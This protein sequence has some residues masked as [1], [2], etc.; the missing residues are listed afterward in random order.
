MSQYLPR[1]FGFYPNINALD[2][3]L[4]AATPRQTTSRCKGRTVSRK[5]SREILIPAE[6]SLDAAET[7]AERIHFSAER[8]HAFSPISHN[9]QRT[10]RRNATSFPRARATEQPLADIANKMH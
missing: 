1:G 9:G 10:M 2:V 6:S 8:Q 4:L 3:S 7:I 5:T